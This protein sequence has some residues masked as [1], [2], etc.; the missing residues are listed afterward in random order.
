MFWMD[1]E[2]KLNIEVT[3]IVWHE[4]FRRYH[5]HTQK[6]DASDAKYTKMVLAEL[7]EVLLLQWVTRTNSY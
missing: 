5:T 4:V 6:E 7:C 1:I 3:Y 2:I